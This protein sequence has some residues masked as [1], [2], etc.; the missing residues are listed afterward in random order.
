MK[1][2]FSN[3][4]LLIPIFSLCLGAKAPQLNKEET[5]SMS[6][7]DAVDSLKDQALNA[8]T[9]MLV[10]KELIK[11]E[12]LDGKKRRLFVE[13]KNTMG[14]RYAIDSVTYKIDG[15][16]VYSFL[17]N[18]VQDLPIEQRVPKNFDTKLVTGS[19]LFEVQVIYKG[20]DSGIFSYLRDY[21]VTKEEKLNINIDTSDSTKIEVTSYEKGW[22]FTDFKERPQ[23]KVEAS[24]QVAKK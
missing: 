19:H 4:L 10:L 2:C 5:N 17:L 6:Y 11:K 12:G 1:I 15:D 8:K 14:S 24:S 18:D 13:F 20:N 9:Q 3:Y 21:S 16:T 7:A 23:L 22:V